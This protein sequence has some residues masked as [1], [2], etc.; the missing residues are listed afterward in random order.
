MGDPGCRAGPDQVRR[1]IEVTDRLFAEC[2]WTREQTHETLRPYLLEEAHEVLEALDAGDRD[3]LREELGDLLM[4]IVFHARYAAG[5][6]RWDIDDVAAGIADK[7]IRRS[8]HVFAEG[9][10]ATAD[11]VDAAWQVIKAAEKRRTRPDEG[12]AASLPALARA[13]KVLGR[14]PDVDLDGDDLGSRLLRLVAE[15]QAQGLDAEGEL[16]RAVTAR[17]DRSAATGGEDSGH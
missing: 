16:R 6:G 15:A 10:A 17:L 7:L 11:E 1:L 9:Q 8:P 13:Q 4:Q 5:E 14:V 12:I 3:H 2:P